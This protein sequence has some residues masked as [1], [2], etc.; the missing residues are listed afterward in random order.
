MEDNDLNETRIHR[1][2]RERSKADVERLIQASVRWSKESLGV[3]DGIENGLRKCSRDG[4]LNDP[5]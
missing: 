2:L 5:Q 3:S 4:S 1:I